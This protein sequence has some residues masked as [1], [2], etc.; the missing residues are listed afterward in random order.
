MNNHRLAIIA[1]VFIGLAL[2]PTVMHSYLG[3]RADD[4]RTAAAVPTSLSGLTSRP[5]DR[6]AAWVLRTLDSSDWS[7]RHYR[8]PNGGDITLFIARSYDGKRLYH[9]PE[10]AIAYGHDLRDGGIVQVQTPVAMTIHT[11]R[12]PT[13]LGT[14]LAVYALLYGREF[15]DNPYVFEL[16]R[17]GTLLFRPRQPLTLFFAHDREAPADTAVEEALVTRVLTAAAQSFLAQTAPRADE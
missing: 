7:E 15:I 9:H 1:A 11:L 16:R 6:Q 4:G 8:K 10:L 12:G 3:L 14:G 5:S 2:T 17:A 13:E